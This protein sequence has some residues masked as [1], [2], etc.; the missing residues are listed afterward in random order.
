MILAA[1]A[2]IAAGQ[3]F[4]C[5]DIALHDGDTTRCADGTRVRLPRIDAIAIS[6]W[7]PGANRRDTMSELKLAQLPDRAPVKLAISVMPDLNGRLAAYADFI[8]RP[9]VAMNRSPI[10]SPRCL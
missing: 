9:T 4:D 7:R 1:L 8:A 5:R 10:S 6:F 3:H 2:L